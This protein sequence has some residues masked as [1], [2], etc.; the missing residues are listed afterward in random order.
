MHPDL[1]LP[2]GNGILNIRV[3]AIIEKN[4]RFL[5]AENDGMDFL[6]TVGGRVRFGE[7]TEE[8]I[9]REVR[10][11]LGVQLEIDHLVLIMEDFFTGDTKASLGKPVHEL[12]FFYALKV[13]ED[14]DPHTA[15]I[16]DDNHPERLVWAALDT[17]KPI[18]PAALKNA[19]AEPGQNIQH[20]IHK[21]SV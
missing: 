12:D 6:Y 3:G 8:A 1:T 18:V 7:T 14:F 5:F 17:P 15:S 21:Q 13:S 2:A 20:R 11:E 16:T 10:E 4:G 9:L 19:L